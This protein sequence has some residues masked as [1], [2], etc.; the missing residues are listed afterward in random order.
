[1]ESSK[2][3]IWTPDKLENPLV[4]QAKNAVEIVV[5]WGN[6]SVKPGAGFESKS[7]LTGS[8]WKTDPSPFKSFEATENYMA[9]EPRGDGRANYRSAD[10]YS[11]GTSTA[12]YSGSLGAT[13]DAIFASAN[14]TGSFDRAIQENKDVSVIQKHLLSL[15]SI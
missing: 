2:D 10:S 11:H 3:F 1:M 4:T 8:P 14:V 15:S 9:Y 5:P 7:M 6:E 13:V 12:H